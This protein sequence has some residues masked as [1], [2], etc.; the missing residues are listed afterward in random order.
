MILEELHLVLNLLMV[1]EVCDCPAVAH[2]GAGRSVSCFRCELST[3]QL[4]TPRIFWEMSIV[5]P[6]LPLERKR[7]LLNRLCTCNVLQI[8]KVYVEKK[9][10]QIV[11]F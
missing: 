8:V 5:K 3:A 2:S 1:A 10:L 4:F 11:S 7:S 9:Y 6:Y